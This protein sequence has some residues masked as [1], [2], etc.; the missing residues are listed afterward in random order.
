VVHECGR[1]RF[2]VYIGTILVVTRRGRVLPIS[3]YSM[4]RRRP[5]WDPFDPNVL[6]VVD[7]SSELGRDLAISLQASAEDEEGENNSISLTDE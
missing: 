4:E 2:Y 1:C 6:S 3:H 7:P 5:A